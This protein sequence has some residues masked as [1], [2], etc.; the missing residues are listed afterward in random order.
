MYK[1]ILCQY[2][3]KMENFENEKK[4]KFLEHCADPKLR[5][6]CTD[7]VFLDT[8]TCNIINIHAI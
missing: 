3:F 2:I 8:D 1:S 4:G 5:F 6:N 7:I